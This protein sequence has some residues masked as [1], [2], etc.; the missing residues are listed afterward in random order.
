MT[1][2]HI[3]LLQALRA[4]PIEYWQLEERIGEAVSRL[5][6]DLCRLGYAVRGEHFITITQKGLLA[7]PSRRA[8]IYTTPRRGANQYTR[9]GF[10]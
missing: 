2:A 7:C 4:G 3:S 5:L 6:T 9:K 10:N 8:S 1:D